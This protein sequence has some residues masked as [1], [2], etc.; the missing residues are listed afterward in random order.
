[1]SN[2]KNQQ[3]FIK[4]VEAIVDS[5][6]KQSGATQWHIGTIRG[7]FNKY[8]ALVEMQNLGESIQIPTNPNVQFFPGEQVFVVYI[9][10]DK[11]NKYVLSKCAT[12]DE[13]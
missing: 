11:R 4:Y 3:D 2:L 7:V 5:K 8:S 9:N 6:L 1:M 10:G 13:K 12:G